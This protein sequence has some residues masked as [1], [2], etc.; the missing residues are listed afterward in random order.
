MTFRFWLVRTV[1]SR[2]LRVS[3]WS[4]PRSWPRCGNIQHGGDF[5][6]CREAAPVTFST[7]SPGTSRRHCNPRAGRVLEASVHTCLQQPAHPPL[8]RLRAPA[9][10]LAP[11]GYFRYKCGRRHWRVP[12]QWSR[13]GNQFPCGP[14]L[15]SVPPCKPVGGAGLSRALAQRHPRPRNQDPEP[16][17]HGAAMPLP[18]FLPTPDRRALCCPFWGPGTPTLW[19]EPSE[20][21]WSSGRGARILLQQDCGRSSAA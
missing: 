17:P 20:Q 21:L 3:R 14:L 12:S 8:K 18:N 16:E 10:T 5:Q 19:L 11:P 7:P 15:R 9:S 4:E 1:W 13:P 6:S 2:P